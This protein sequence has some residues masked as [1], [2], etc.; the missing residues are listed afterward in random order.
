MNSTLWLEFSPSD[1]IACAWF[2][3]CWVG[4][5]QAADRSRLWKRSMTAAMHGHRQGWMAAMLKRE[6]RIVDIQIIGNQL[7]GAAFF[8]STTILA[9][10]GL[11]ALLGATDK[12]IHDAYQTFNASARPFREEAKTHD[13]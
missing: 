8:A 6:N 10:G 5:T 12:A 2:L 7:N 11:F 1:V 4:Y 3:I 9:V 13:H